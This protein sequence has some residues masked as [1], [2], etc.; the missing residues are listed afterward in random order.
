[1]PMV[2][3]ISAIKEMPKNHVHEY[4]MFGNPLNKFPFKKQVEPRPG[5]GRHHRQTRLYRHQSPRNKG[6]AVNP[7]NP[8]RPQG[9]RLFVLGADPATDIAVIK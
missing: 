2:V 7:H 5:I 1:M 9:V 4:D 3:N 6:H 8:L